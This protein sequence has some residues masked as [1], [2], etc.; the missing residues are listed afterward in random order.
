MIKDIIYFRI[1]KTGS[2]T[3]LYIFELNKKLLKKCNI[4]FHE[5]GHRSIQNNSINDV[6]NKYVNDNK[7]NKNTYII[8]MTIRN[9]LDHILSLYSHGD[10][11]INNIKS[12]GFLGVNEKYNIKSYD[13]F[14]ELIS[15]NKI[16]EYNY[17][18][19][20][21]D[22]YYY[23]YENSK[24]F[25][26]IRTENLITDLAKISEKYISKS[27]IIPDIKLNTYNCN[28]IKENNKL[29]RSCKPDNIIKIHKKYS[30]LNKNIFYEFL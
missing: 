27:F 25:K 17:W 6:I 23:G 4:N 2:T 8:L 29:Y 21:Y 5:I 19:G 11:R 12:T 3:L 15:K 30:Y 7:I 20:N 9:T 24:N 26:L 13:E 16:L 10:Y 1:P 14:F 22:N 18:F 28:N